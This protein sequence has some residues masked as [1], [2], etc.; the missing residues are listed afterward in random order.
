LKYIEKYAIIFCRNSKERKSSIHCKRG[1]NEPH[2]NPKK[3]RPIGEK[4]TANDHS[5]T[6]QAHF[7]FF[8]NDTKSFSS[9]RLV[10]LSRSRFNI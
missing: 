1:K 9:P 10:Q 7:V 6:C 8:M 2:A 5:R 4:M 3:S